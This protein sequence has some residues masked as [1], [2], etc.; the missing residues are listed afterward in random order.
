MSD[1]LF[2]PLKAKWYNMIESGI[3]P[4]D[5]RDIKD[6][7]IQRLIEINLFYEFPTREELIEITEEGAIEEYFKDFDAVQFSYGYTKRTMLFECKGITI[8]KGNPEWGAPKEYVFIIK[9]GRRLK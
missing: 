1:T 9:R 2:L 7:W 5:Y 3:K 6:Y 4:E 8:G